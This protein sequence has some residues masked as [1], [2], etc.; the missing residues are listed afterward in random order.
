MKSAQ[1]LFLLI[2]AGAAAHADFSYT[3][4]LKSGSGPMGPGGD[5][6]SKVY[7]KGDK[8]KTERA[9]STTIIDLEAQ[10]L[11]RIDRT[12]KTY[13]VTKFNDLG[14]GAHAVDLD[15]KA[16]VKSTGQKKTI[17][18]YNASQVVM[19]MEMD[20][21]QAQQAGIKPQMEIE[22]WVS[23]DV[24]GTQELRAFYRRNA[25]RFPWAAMASGGNPGMQKAI[26]N[27]QRRMAELDGVPV[28]QVVRLK[29]GGGAGPSS[30]QM[31]QMAEARAQLEALTKQGGAQAAAAQQALARMGA[32]TGSGSLM[33][34]TTESSGF[35]TST[36]PEAVFDVPVGYGK[37]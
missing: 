27:L 20:M 8:M 36:I 18:G 13:T 34:I 21:P 28:L 35:S 26:A 9:N 31:A 12:N 22:I 3:N 37:K 5:Q 17:N 24:P 19:T 7:F 16:E 29:S 2:G 23:P 33:E 4:T 6:T 25:S 15:V 10:T 32:M 30:A 11:T 14:A 1:I